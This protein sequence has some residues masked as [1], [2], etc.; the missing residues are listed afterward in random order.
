MSGTPPP[1]LVSLTQKAADYAVKLLEK[2]GIKTPPGGIRFQV[3]SGGCHGLEY[4]Y[5]LEHTDNPR[6]III[7]S[8]GVR[9]LV[10][11]KSADILR[12]TI[13]DHSDNLLEK[14][15]FFNNPNAKSSC[16]CG[17]SFET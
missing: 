9:I 15:F 4:I 5:E 16:G 6:D 1:P 2:E 13:I 7:L 8:R 12:G 11:S 10:D 3:K 14:P 17:Q